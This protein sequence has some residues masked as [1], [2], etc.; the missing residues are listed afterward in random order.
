MGVAEKVVS[1]VAAQ[2]GAGGVSHEGDI[3]KGLDRRRRHE[4]LPGH[5]RQD[6]PRL[7][8]EGSTSR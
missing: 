2:I 6:V 7:A 3:A 1:D 5:R 8:D 4:D